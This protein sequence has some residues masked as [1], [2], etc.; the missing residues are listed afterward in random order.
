MKHLRKFSTKYSLVEQSNESYTQQDLDELKEFCDDHLSY[1]IDEDY[2]VS[3]QDFE[4]NAGSVL[5]VV[6]RPP[7]VMRKNNW[8]TRLKTNLI[9]EELGT[10]FS[11]FKDRLIPFVYMLLKDY[12]L[13]TNEEMDRMELGHDEGGMGFAMPNPNSNILDTKMVRVSSLEHLEQVEDNLMVS[14]F[15]IRIKKKD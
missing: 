3:V 2:K 4:T 14:T 1:L 7:K 6:V 12:R 11:H 8:A 9:E 10:P 5:Q 15:Y 13:I